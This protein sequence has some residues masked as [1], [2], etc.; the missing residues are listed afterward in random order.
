MPTNTLQTANAKTV[1]KLLDWK[2][3]LPSVLHVGLDDDDDEANYLPHV[4]LLQYA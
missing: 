1:A 2:V 4:I 3:N